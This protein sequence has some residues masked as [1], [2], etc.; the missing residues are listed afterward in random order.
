MGA[1]ID[2][3]KN[4]RPG[5]SPVQFLLFLHLHRISLLAPPVG[6]FT[7]SLRLV[8]SPLLAYP[9]SFPGGILT[10]IGLYRCEQTES[11]C[12]HNPLEM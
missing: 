5:T 12:P 6:L 1:L 8:H 9:L 10:P 3:C 7:N 11:G 4:T 2:A